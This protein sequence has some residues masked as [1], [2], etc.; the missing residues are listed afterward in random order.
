MNEVEHG[1][2]VSNRGQVQNAHHEDARP[3][4]FGKLLRRL[5]KE[6]GMNCKAL[7]DAAGVS[8]RTIDRAQPKITCPWK[9]STARKVLLAIAA[10]RPVGEADR[11][12]F[13]KMSKLAGVPLG[14]AKMAGVA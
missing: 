3:E 8:E 13:C 14:V 9:A 11:V 6:R 7:A 5:R 10:V 1:G 4:H 12:A 2:A